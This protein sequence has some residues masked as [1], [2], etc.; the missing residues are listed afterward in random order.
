MPAPPLLTSFCGWPVRSAL[1][2]MSPERIQAVVGH[3]EDAAD[4]GRLAAIEEQ[5][6]L[7]R[8][9]VAVAARAQ[10]AERDER[11]EEVARRARVQAEPPAERRRSAA[12][13]CAS[14]V[15]TPISM[16][17]RR[18]FDG[19]NARPVCMIRSGLSWSD[20][21]SS[22]DAAAGAPEWRG[23]AHPVEGPDITSC[24]P[25]GQRR[26]AAE[27]APQQACCC[28]Q[29]AHPG[30]SGRRACVARVESAASRSSEHGPIVA[31]PV[32]LKHLARIPACFSAR[33][34][35]ICG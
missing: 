30:S 31:I 7:G 1:G 15:K 5:I 6:G 8:V 34:S 33:N 29:L 16:A 24:G 20:I 35:R 28:Q 3:L 22:L 23:P 26:F 13:R 17:L 27:S 18:V 4:V 11:I 9:G 32:A 25:Q 14:S 19:Q 10:E 21:V 2:E 12:G